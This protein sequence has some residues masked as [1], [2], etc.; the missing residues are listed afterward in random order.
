MLRQT[1]RG[2]KERW[3][4]QVED[5]RSG[6]QTFLTSPDPSFLED[7]VR[8]QPDIAAKITKID[9]STS[10][11]SD[12]RFG[13]LKRFPHLAEI[14]FNEVSEG[15]DSFLK[16]IA[17]MESITS[18]SFSKT[19]LGE[20]GVRA[21]ASFPHLKQLSIDYPWK[22]TN[23]QPLSGHKGIETLILG[24]LP[25]TKERI[26]FMLSLPKLRIVDLQDF[27]VVTEADRQKLRMELPNVKLQHNAL[28]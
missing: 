16:Q 8:D 13:V 5:V 3:E 10:I 26:D 19:L 22:D 9:F 21:V 23:L 1:E 6:Q 14:D 24:E 12:E 27:D 4:R 17:G 2:I 11:V 25:I 18:L 28:R 15:A 7:F 20:D